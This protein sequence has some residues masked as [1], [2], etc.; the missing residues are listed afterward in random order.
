VDLVVRSANLPRPGETVMAGDVVRLPGGKGANQ[1]AAA[2]R[3]GARVSLMTSLGND[4]AG[5]WMCTVLEGYGVSLD[6]VQR[7]L[8]PT[9]TAFITVDEHGENEIVV[10]PGA[11]HD[12][13][14]AGLSFESFDV[15]LAQMEVTQRVVDDVARRARQL[16]LNV[17]PVV[18]VD[19]ETLARCA[20]VIANEIE[21]EHF[22]VAL[23][24]HCVLTLGERGAVHLR[25]GREIARSAAPRIVPID[26]VG[27][28]DV[29]CAAYVLQFA[30][31]ASAQDALDFAVVAG[32]LAT[33]AMGAQGALPIRE[34]VEQWLA[35]G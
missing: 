20:V 33:L 29:F 30:E 11:N 14:V 10:S 15:V 32:S 5:E 6:Q 4:D 22:D 19:P 35:R 12:L 2:A 16:V 18:P 3:L 9:G 17:A 27:A 25:R 34:E 24:E 7:S 23:I 8:R 31:G 21:A 13:D 26:T 28:G 1:A